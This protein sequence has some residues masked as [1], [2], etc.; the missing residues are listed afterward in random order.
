MVSILDALEHAWG[1]ITSQSVKYTYQS[2]YEIAK[3]RLG[4][5]E[6]YPPSAGTPAAKIISVALLNSK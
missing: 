3:E 2:T 6:N 5:L 1:E 4:D